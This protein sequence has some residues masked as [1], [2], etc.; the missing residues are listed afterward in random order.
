MR[1]WILVAVLAL[2]TAF[3]ARG[4]TYD[5][6]WNGTT[7]QGKAI[8]F[9]IASNRLTVLTFGGTASATGCST[10]F[11]QTTNFTTPRSFSTPSFVITG[12]T[13]T[14]GSI[15]WSLSGTFASETSVSGNL[16][17]NS[18]GIP[19]V[20]GCS[21]SGSTSWSATR[22]GGPPPPPPPPAETLAGIFAAVGSLQGSGG[23]F[24]TAVQLHNPGTTPLAGKL[25]FHRAGV[26]GASS[27]PSLPYTLAARQTLSYADLLPAMGQSGLGSL[28]LITTQGS[29][30]LTAFRIFNDAG[31]AGTS[32]MSIEPLPTTQALQSGQTGVLL[33]PQDLTR[34][35]LNIGVRTL[36]AGVSLQITVRDSGGVIRHTTTKTLG[37]TFFTQ[38]S[39]NSFL[40]VELVPGDTIDFAINSGNAIIYGAVTDNVT[41]DPTLQYAKPAF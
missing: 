40:G 13:A 5:G 15:S 20:G 14:P 17:F 41:N 32:G 35:R 24:K 2:T 28:D 26:S 36:S 22:P 39:A 12:G 3:A 25:V 30:P 11:T 9:T 18:Y 31:A 21:G 38:E 29:A 10:T 23:F 6:V 33:A 27:D 1:R 8:T 37:P 16:S 19:G 4:Q 7:G 34:F